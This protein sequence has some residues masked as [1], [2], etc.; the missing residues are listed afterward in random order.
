MSQLKT[1]WVIFANLLICWRGEEILSYTHNTITLRMYESKAFFR[2]IHP[3][4]HLEQVKSSRQLALIPISFTLRFFPLG[5]NITN[6][7]P[8]IR[9]PHRSH[10]EREEQHCW[11]NHPRMS[12]A[13]VSYRYS[14]RFQISWI[15]SCFNQ[16][17]ILSFDCCGYVADLRF[18][19][20]IRENRCVCLCWFRIDLIVWYYN[21]STS[22]F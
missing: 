11:F 2:E 9:N 8:N 6:P 13:D 17:Y 12:Q 10:E 22:L 7:T 18:G 20:K 16:S 5:K 3:R 21:G 4:D 15:G 1:W 14:N 19:K